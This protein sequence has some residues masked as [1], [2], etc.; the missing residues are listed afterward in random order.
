MSSPAIMT[1]VKMMESLSEDL[2]NKV[3]EHLREYL[4]GLQTKKQFLV[5]PGTPKDGKSKFL[6]ELGK[7]MDKESSFWE[8]IVQFR[9]ELIEEEIAINP[10]EVW[11]NIRDYVPGCEVIW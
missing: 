9:Q 11:G 1:V 2:Q 8:S 3:A 10:D 6:E 7:P 5:I 4:E